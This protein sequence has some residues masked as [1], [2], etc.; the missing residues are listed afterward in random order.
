M[1]WYHLNVSIHVLA[2]LVWLGG[3]FF[4]AL[5]G[6]PALRTIESPVLRAQLFRVLGERFRKVGWICIAILLI[7]GALNLHFRGLLSDHVLNGTIWATSY[8]RTLAIKLLA[9]LG[10][11]IIQAIHDFLHGP[12]ASR[13]MPGSESALR[14]R[15]RAA[16]MARASALLGIIVLLAAVRL[17]RP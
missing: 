5:V 17:T 3:M 10:M 12:A 11:L 6:A 2:A 8:G 9:V 13:A 14:M 15:R 16:L 1:S 4:L 7:T